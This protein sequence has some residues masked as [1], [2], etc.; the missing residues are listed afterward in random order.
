[1][2]ESNVHTVSALCVSR[3]HRRTTQCVCFHFTMSLTSAVVAFG[4]LAGLDGGQQTAFEI[5]A[6]T[7]VLTFYDEANDNL[8]EKEDQDAS[9]ERSKKLQTLARRQSTHA[10]LPNEPLRMFVTGPAGAGKCK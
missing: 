4:R 7:Y 6:A 3:S 10:I 1:M 9:T 8:D 5:L 2:F